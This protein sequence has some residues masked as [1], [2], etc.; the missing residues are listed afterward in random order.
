MSPLPTAALRGSCVT[1]ILQMRV[2]NVSRILL[3]VTGPQLPP[4]PA[5]PVFFPL[6]QTQAPA[7][8]QRRFPRLLITHVFTCMFFL[9]QNDI[10]PLSHSPHRNSSS[11]KPLGLL[12][13][14]PCLQQAFHKPKKNFV[15]S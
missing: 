8:T 12:P 3:L 9:T 2:P 15:T 7:G 11:T 5:Y 13:P 14:T 6:S 10:P 1:P 4:R